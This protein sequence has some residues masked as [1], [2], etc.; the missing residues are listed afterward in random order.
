MVGLSTSAFAQSTAGNV[1]DDGNY[2]PGF[3]CSSLSTAKAK[4]DCETVESNRTP[5]NDA[6][7]PG[8]PAIEMPGEPN[9]MP[10]PNQH[11][12][13]PNNYTINNFIRGKGNSNR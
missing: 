10:D 1:I 12:A 13:S 11:G 2:P 8:T 5:D 7:P 6:V 9:V 3:D 4:L